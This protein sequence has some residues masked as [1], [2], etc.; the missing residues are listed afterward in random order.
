MMHLHDLGNDHGDGDDTLA[1]NGGGEQLEYG[2]HERERLHNW[3]S[4]SNSRSG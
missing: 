4:H 3:E 1:A 2:H